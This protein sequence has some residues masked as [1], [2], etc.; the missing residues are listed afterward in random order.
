MNLPEM[1]AV[2]SPIAGAA[3]VVMAFMQT[4]R[5]GSSSSVSLLVG[6]PLGLVGGFV[7]YRGMVRL[8][9]EVSRADTTQNSTSWRV[10]AILG[11]TMLAPFISFGI[12]F[13][14]LRLV[15]YVAA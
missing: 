5:H 1:S 9:R 4:H 15:Y 14:L 3:G 8:A 10:V 6:I 7:I 13:W 2:L 12:C 11:L